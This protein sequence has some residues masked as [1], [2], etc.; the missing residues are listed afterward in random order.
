MDIPTGFEDIATRNKVCKLKKSLYELKRS[1]RAWF[2]RFSRVPK[3]HHYLQC[4]TDHTLFVRHTSEG[5]CSILSVYVDDIA[6]TGNDEEEIHRLKQILSKEFE[7]KDLGHMKYFLG[8]EVA[9]SKEGIS[10]SQRKY[11]IDLLKDTGMIGCKPVET[12]MDPNV[13]IT[14]RVNE[15]AADKG[16]YQRLVGRLIYLSHTRPDIRFSVSVVSRFM[17]NPSEL[18]ME[19]VLRILRY[20]KGNPGTGLMF[21]KNQNREVTVYTD[22]DWAGSTTDRRSTSRYCSYIWAT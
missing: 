22:A 16:Q 18:H 14:A 13:K 5:K 12:P 21:R 20:L 11:V 4:Q 15:T 7:I 6:I 1:P 2:D 19:V 3:T 17:N 8:M 9:R 10:V